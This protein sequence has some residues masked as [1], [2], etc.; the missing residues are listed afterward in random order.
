MKA[1]THTGELEFNSQ[2][3][4][5]FLKEFGKGKDNTLAVINKPVIYLVGK[6]FGR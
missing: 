4:E 1:Q 6:K 5:I 2:F 3:S